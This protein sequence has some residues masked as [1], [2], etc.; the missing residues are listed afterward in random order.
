MSIVSSLI[1]NKS[2]LFVK[3]IIINMDLF[4]NETLGNNEF[5][6][7]SKAHLLI[8]GFIFSMIFLMFVYKEILKRPNI[9]IKFGRIIAFILLL[10]SFFQHFWYIERKVFTLKESLPLYLCRIT[11]LLCIFMLLKESY[12]LFEIVYFWGLG[13]ATQ[14]LITP[15]TGGFIFPHWMYIQFF[16]GHG[17]IL[18]SIFFMI[19][20]YGYRPTIKS[21]KKTFHWS[22]IYL[23]VVG[24]FNYLVDGNY[25]YLRGKPLTSSVLDFFP[26]YPY[27]IPIL[28]AGMFF[29]FI[30][31]YIPF[32]I[33]DNKRKKLHNIINTSN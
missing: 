9:R 27:Y 19:L 8:L 31:L 3:S 32:Y 1:T 26:K 13:G 28:I 14:A 7:F 11:V 33:Y 2:K 4:W 20:S 16:I 25:S 18:I 21:L 10:Q 23:I 12:S 22:Y 30:L 15:D 24:M 6:L 5:N 17:G 29:I